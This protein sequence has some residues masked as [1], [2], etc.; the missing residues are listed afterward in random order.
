MLILRLITRHRSLV[1]SNKKQCMAVHIRYDYKL[2]IT[3]AKAATLRKGG[4]DAPVSAPL[5]SAAKVNQGRLPKNRGTNHQL[6]QTIFSLRWKIS[7]GNKASKGDNLIPKPRGF[8]W[9]H[10]DPQSFWRHKI[11]KEVESTN[12][13]IENFPKSPCLSTD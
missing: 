12:V 10:F 2:M 1:E 4:D 7:T 8:K 13:H 3:C 5:S 6:K 11:R 9:V